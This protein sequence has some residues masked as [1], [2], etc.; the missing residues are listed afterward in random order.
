LPQLGYFGPTLGTK[1]EPSM[2][3]KVETCFV[4]APLIEDN[5][6]VKL[7]AEQVRQQIDTTDSPL[8]A[9]PGAQGQACTVAPHARADVPATNL[10][11]GL[12]LPSGLPTKADIIGIYDGGGGFDC[13]V[14]RPAGRCR[15][16]RGLS[17]TT[18]FCAVCRY[19]IVDHLD[20]MAHKVLDDLYEQQFPR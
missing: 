3:A 16:R 9:P 13:E 14:F 20:P 17:A 11:A 8:N 19:F 15:M 1:L 2:F 6:E 10:P 4:I 5:N 12:S 7:V 18:P